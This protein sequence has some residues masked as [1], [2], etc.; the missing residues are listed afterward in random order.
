MV[1]AKSKLP[2]FRTNQLAVRSTVSFLPPQLL[3]AVGVLFSPVVS[4][5]AGGGKKFVRAVSHK[6]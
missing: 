2:F 6:P 4:G 1:T 3:R 5:R